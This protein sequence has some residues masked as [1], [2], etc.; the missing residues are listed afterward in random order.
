[1][2]V[3]SIPC[4]SDFRVKIQKLRSGLF[5]LATELNFRIVP[6]QW[7]ATKRLRHTRRKPTSNIYPFLFLRVFSVS[8][9]AHLSCMLKL[10]QADSWG[11]WTG[12]RWRLGRVGRQRMQMRHKGCGAQTGI[13]SH[14]QQHSRGD[15]TYNNLL[16][17]L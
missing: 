2:N 8:Q 13:C 1:M 16:H 10:K 14:V 7:Q 4:E 3:I 11:A 5:P 12:G 9:R 6:S 17:I 15:E